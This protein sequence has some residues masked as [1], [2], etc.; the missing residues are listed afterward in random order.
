MSLLLAS[1]LAASLMTPAGIDLDSPTIF[2]SEQARAAVAS[3]TAPQFVCVDL[4][5]RSR[6]FRSACVTTAEWQQAVQL[7]EVAARRR[8]MGWRSHGLLPQP[9]PSQN[10]PSHQS[11]TLR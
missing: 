6:K 10:H 4:P 8:K 7:A 2:V 9:L 1:A 11:W 3:G 5:E